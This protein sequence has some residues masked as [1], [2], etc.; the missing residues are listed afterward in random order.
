ML[1]LSFKH[2]N[3]VYE[4][5]T[6]TDPSNMHSLALFVNQQ[7]S[8]HPVG[9]EGRFISYTKLHLLQKAINGPRDFLNNVDTLLV[10]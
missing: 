7:N 1:L 6:S 4:P 3:T 10:E 8:V 9:S 2:G 5:S